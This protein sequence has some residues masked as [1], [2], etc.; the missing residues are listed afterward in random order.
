MREADLPA[1]QPEAQ[2]EAR[3][4]HPDAHSCRPGRGQGPPGARTRPALGLIYRI[5]RRAIFTELARGRPRRQGPVWVRR[6]GVDDGPPQVAFAVGRPVGNA[7]TR[8]RLRRRL[9]VVVAR[10]ESELKPATAYLIG[11][12]RAASDLGTDALERTVVAALA[13]RS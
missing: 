11:A 7:V 5:R 2:E 13:S 8:N 9:R 10:H 12:G 3:V 6:L 4:P 1:E